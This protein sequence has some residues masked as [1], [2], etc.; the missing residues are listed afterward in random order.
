MLDLTPERIREV[1]GAALLT[2]GPSR[3]GPADAPRRVV[4]DSRHVEPG[5]LF[6]GIRG[7]RSDGGDFAATA[8]EA[9]A[10]GVLVRPEQAQKVA[11]IAG[12]RIRV[13]A[14]DDPL[15]ALGRL[16]RAWVDRL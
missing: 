3:V 1:C 6:V 12:G 10:W 14:V 11:G 2:G 9:G 7:E 15:E 8:I 4:A 13:L 16:A 5:D